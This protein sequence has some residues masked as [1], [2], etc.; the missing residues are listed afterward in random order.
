MTDKFKPMDTFAKTTYLVKLSQD[1]KVF[2]RKDGKGDD[3]VITFADN[4]RITGTETLWVDAKPRSFA[5]DRVSK[6]K[7]G[8]VVQV[9]GKLRFKKQDDGSMRGKI[10]DAEIDSFVR[11]APPDAEDAVPE[12]KGTGGNV[13]S[14]RP[15]FE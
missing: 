11:T 13:E 4:S 2:P 6:Y 3:V 15:A 10:F 8:D 12:D 9:T 1:A 5:N 14:S 7:K